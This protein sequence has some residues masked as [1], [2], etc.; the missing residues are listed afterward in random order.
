MVQD[1]DPTNPDAFRACCQP[2]ILNGTTGAIQIRIAHRGTAQHM[3]TSPLTTT[4]H[5][6]IDRRFLDP[7]QLEAPIERG[8][9]PL[10]ARCRL[11]V[12][13]QEQVFHRPLGRTIANHDKVPGLH[14]SHRS[15]MVGCGQHTRQDLGR[16]RRR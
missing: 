3:R 1:T 12:R 13:L 8:T 6:N 7:F 10:I 14:E 9:R 5:A 16:N 2:E 4:G 11:G 15:S